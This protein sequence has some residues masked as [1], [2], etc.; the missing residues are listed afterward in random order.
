M[1][2]RSPGLQKRKGG[3]YIDKHIRGY[4]R[5]CESCQTDSLQEAEK[6]LARRREQIREALVYGVR[7][8]RTF[9]QA[10]QKYLKENQHKRSLDRDV[11]ALN[12]VMADIGSLPLD[13]IHNDSLSPY[14]VRRL[15]QGMAVGTINK[16]LSTVRRVLNL[17]ARVWRDENGLSWLAAPPLIQML[18]GPARKPY[19]LSW[20]EQRQ[21]FGLLPKHLEQMV[22]FKVNTGTRQNEVCELQWDWE[23][24]VPEL[25]T[26]LFIIPEWLAKNGLERIIVLNDVARKVIDQQ[27]GQHPK[28]VFTYKGR[29]LARLMTSAWKNA[30]RKAGL[31][32][33]RIHDLKHTFGH[34]LRAAGVP[35]EERQDLLGHRSARITTHYSAPDI[36]RL[37]EAAERVC[38]PALHTVLRIESHAKV[39]HDESRPRPALPKLSAI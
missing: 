11:Y 10:A 7:P 34:R 23:V 39:T 17:A 21:L 36:A 2:K 1:A 28:Y 3:W 14:K 8:T 15:Q 38:K 20:P 37:I 16:E 33:V 6:Y 13:R 9:S 26:T 35:F 27:R 12:A 25:E 5:L 32:H 31:A 4:G 22:L 24:S 30:R 29:P 18:K 19:P